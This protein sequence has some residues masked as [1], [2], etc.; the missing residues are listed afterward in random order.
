M[1]RLISC[2]WM[3]E[4]LRSQLCRGEERIGERGEDQM[5]MA[6]SLQPSA[7]TE[8]WSACEVPLST[9]MSE[10]E[11]VARDKEIRTWVQRKKCDSMNVLHSH[12]LSVF[13]FLSLVCLLSLS[14]LFMHISVYVFAYLWCACAHARVY[15]FMW[16]VMSENQAH[17]RS[18]H[19]RDSHYCLATGPFGPEKELR[20]ESR[21]A[22]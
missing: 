5:P 1:S 6:S 14:F 21:S 7:V 15:V 4:V 18:R 8:A 9:A 13:T 12:S 2:G 11:Q 10:W 17:G 19:L 22:F 16:K 3:P 20:R